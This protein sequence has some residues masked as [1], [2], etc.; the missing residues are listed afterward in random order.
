MTPEQRALLYAAYA[1][2]PFVPL[3]NCQHLREYATH[4][5]IFCRDCHQ[6]REPVTDFERGQVSRLA[7]KRYT[8]SFAMKA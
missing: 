6:T 8:N 5:G 4:T 3:A 1:P 7:P 2:R